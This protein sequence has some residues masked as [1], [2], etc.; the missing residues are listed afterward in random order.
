MRKQTQILRISRQNKPSE[1]KII[2]CPRQPVNRLDADC[3][4]IGKEG[5]SVELG[6]GLLLTWHDYGDEYEPGGPVQSGGGDIWA[7]SLG[8]VIHGAM[9]RRKGI[10]R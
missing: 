5:L 8:E 1:T 2:L 6:P 9:S 7:A 4:H 3:L 10:Q